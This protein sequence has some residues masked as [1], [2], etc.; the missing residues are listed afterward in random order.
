MIASL[1]VAL[2]LFIMV[3]VILGCDSVLYRLRI[4]WS[5][6]W[7]QRKG[8]QPGRRLPWIYDSIRMLFTLSSERTRFSCS[9]Q[10]CLCPLVLSFD[11]GAACF[12]PPFDEGQDQ[13]RW[14]EA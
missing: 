4:G 2:R 7:L 14:V 11:G 6:R 10:P 12:F 5:D 8:A 3:S 1:L 13:D 9:T